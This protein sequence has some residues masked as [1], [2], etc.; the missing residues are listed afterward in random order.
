[1]CNYCRT[2]VVDCFGYSTTR[3]E[4][5]RGGIVHVTGNTSIIAA[6]ANVASSQKMFSQTSVHL[7]LFPSLSVYVWEWDTVMKLQLL[8]T[9]NRWSVRLQADLRDMT[10]GCDLWRRYGMLHRW[11][12]LVCS[13]CGV[14]LLRR[15]SHCGDS[16]QN[17]FRNNINTDQHL[18]Q[19]SSV[20]LYQQPPNQTNVCFQKKETLLAVSC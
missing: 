3:Y 16:L 19:T 10:R 4:E 1:M 14:L 17:Q 15:E 18:W 8:S 12:Y 9:W 5:T 11:R 6:T 7:W 13:V 20:Q 2:I